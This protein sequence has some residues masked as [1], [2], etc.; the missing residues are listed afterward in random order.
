MTGAGAPAPLRAV[1]SDFGG[2]LTTPLIGA[3]AKVQDRHGVPVEALGLAM[4]RI[5]E[6]DGA[7]PLFELECGRMTEAAFLARLGE[8][9]SAEL[10]RPVAMHDFAEAYFEHLD[11][12]HE[13]VAFLRA[14]PA[15]GLRLA[16]LTNNVR[17][18]EP[19]WRAM[20]PV[21]EIF[22]LVVDSAFV[23][24]RKPDPEIYALTLERLGI[25]GEECLF[26]DD[27]EINVDAARAFGMH[28]VWFRDT[29]QAIAD[30]EAALH[31]RR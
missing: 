18:W 1:I 22:E 25:P 8:T 16:L 29:A 3:F 12:N 11:T 5:A 15:H 13:M 17:E 31:Q 10:D 9:L 30:I 20:V 27:I 26:L 28:G 19:H 21:D 24:M 2:V 6:A 7:H 23:G 14:L 4:M